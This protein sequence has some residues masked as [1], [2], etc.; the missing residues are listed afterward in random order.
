MNPGAWERLRGN[1]AKQDMNTAVI[2]PEK[3]NKRY[4]GGLAERA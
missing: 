2:Q 4:K 1:P 3:L